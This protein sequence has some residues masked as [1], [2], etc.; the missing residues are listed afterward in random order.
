MA[1]LTMFSDSEWT[2]VTPEGFFD[3]S[4]G[5][6]D[7]LSIR[8]GAEVLNIDQLYDALY[9]PDLV[10]EALAGDPDGTVAAAAAKLDLRK[11]LASGMP[12]QVMALEA[13]EGR[14][15]ASTSVT[16]EAAIEFG[17]GGIGRLEW[18]VNGVVQ[19]IDDR[20]VDAPESAAEALATTIR[21]KLSLFPGENVISLV[22]YN[23]ANLIASAPVEIVVTSTA[24]GLSAPRLHVLSVGV[25]DYFDDQLD[26][27][28]AAPDA[29]AI[30]ETLRQAGAGLFS[31]VKVT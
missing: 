25:N 19:S 5:A 12:P 9:R 17:S 14:S 29:R 21:Q 23:R 20:S 27:N 6:A 31:E 1:R 24:T 30:G 18:R 3:H 26:L 8:R 22:A 7:R 10:Q 28:Y 2:V 11:V 4:P 15:V 13:A 16:M